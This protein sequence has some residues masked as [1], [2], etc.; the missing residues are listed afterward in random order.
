MNVLKLGYMKKY[1]DNVLYLTTRK[2]RLEKIVKGSVRVERRDVAGSPDKFVLRDA[3]GDYVVDGGHAAP[4]IMHDVREYNDG[5]FPFVLRHID[6]IRYATRDMHALVEV[7]AVTL[8]CSFVRFD[9]RNVTWTVAY[10][11]GAVV[12][13]KEK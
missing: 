5:W 10:H 1:E 9:R 2:D 3:N 8:D 13:L 12:E 4:D 6:F 11:L 7:K